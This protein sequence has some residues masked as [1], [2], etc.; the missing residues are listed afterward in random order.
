MEPPL[1]V[2]TESVSNSVNWGQHCY[3][4]HPD[5][6]CPGPLLSTAL[7]VHGCGCVCVCLCWAHVPHFPAD[8]GIHV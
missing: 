8:S 3:Q 4:L 5:S 2:P 6:E 7:C 1:Q